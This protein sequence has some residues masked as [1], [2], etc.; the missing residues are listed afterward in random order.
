[1]RL[2]YN[3]PREVTHQPEELIISGTLHQHQLL[4]K[5]KE[6]HRNNDWK[7][8]YAAVEKVLRVKANNPIV[9]TILTEENVPIND[10]EEVTATIAK[11]FER[12]YALEEEN[13][14]EEIKD[15]HMEE[16]L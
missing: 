10:E 12:V 5:L 3:K 16:A 4:D 11:Y 1:V 14:R 7:A 2:R 6:Y 15:H 8:F 13:K 9:R